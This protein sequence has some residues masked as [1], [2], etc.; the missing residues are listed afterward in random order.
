M[1]PVFGSLCYLTCLVFFFSHHIPF[2]EFTRSKF[3]SILFQMNYSLA[4]IPFGWCV[5]SNLPF[6]TFL[7]A[8][9]SLLSTLLMLPSLS[10]QLYW[11]CLLS[12]INFIDAVSNVRKPLICTYH[13][14]VNQTKSS[15]CKSGAKPLDSFVLTKAGLLRYI[16]SPETQTQQGVRSLYTPS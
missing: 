4:W 1:K 16:P 15:F 6:S 14:L 12:L 3:L 11:C 10:Y 2:W 8:A 13:I 5:C 9:F 7:D